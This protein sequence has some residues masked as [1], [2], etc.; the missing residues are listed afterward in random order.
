MLLKLIPSVVWIV[1]ILVILFRWHLNALRRYHVQMWIAEKQ[2]E[3]RLIVI[4]RNRHFR[5]LV[6]CI[7]A[8]VALGIGV[9]GVLAVF[10]P[11]A[12][13]FMGIIALL[14]FYGSQAATGWL[15]QRDLRMLDRVEEGE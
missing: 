15:T 10:L 6:R 13:V 14:F 11:K 4:A 7:E 1:M 9:G 12:G 2:G 5:Y 3:P 8:A